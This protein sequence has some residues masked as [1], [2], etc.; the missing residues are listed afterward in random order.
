LTVLVDSTELLAKFPKVRR[1]LPEA[2]QQI[3]V[4]MYEHSRK[5][6]NPAAAAALRLE[7]WMQRQAAA[8]PTFPLLELGAG[9]LNHVPFEPIIGQYDVVE[10]LAK[11]YEGNPNIVRIG[12]FYDSVHDVPQEQTYN[13]IV[14]IAVL[15]HVLDLPALIARSALRLSKRGTMV[16]GIPTEGGLLWY[17]AWRFG[18]GTAFWL[19]YRMSYATFMRHEHVNQSDEITDVMRVFFDDVSVRRFPLPFKHLS[20]YTSLTATG[21]KKDVAQ[22]YLESLG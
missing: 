8:H 5:G 17:L 13:R 18:T 1:P 6:R 14:S 11:L 21:P 2:Y 16:S 20:F 7:Q 19:K 4:D 12:K 15:E 9:T 3:Y 10:P 22:A